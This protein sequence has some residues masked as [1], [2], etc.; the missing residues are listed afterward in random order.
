VSATRDRLRVWA[1]ALAAAGLAAA[2][3]A[4][5]RGGQVCGPVDDET[6]LLPI[7][8]RHAELATYEGDRWLAATARVFSV[9]Y[10]WIVGSLMASIDDPIVALRWL[11]LPFHAV[12]LAGTWRVA[13]RDGGPAAGLVAM[14]LCLVPPLDR[15]VLAPG[16]GLPRDLVFALLPWFL[17]G[18]DATL[19]RPRAGLW[20]F[21]GLGLVANLHP[22]TALHA[23]VWLGAIGLVRDP[24][25]RGLVAALMRGLGFATGAAPYVMQYLARPAAPGAVDQ[26]VYV[27]RL[28]SMGGESV[29]SFALRMETVLL[30][31]A[32]AAVVVL[33]WRKDGGRWPKWFAAAA[34]LALVLAALG[35]TLGRFVVPLRAVQLARF[36]RIAAWCAIVLLASGGVAVWRAGRK[37]SVV[38]AAVLVAAAAWGP[39]L[40]GGVPIRGPLARLGRKL[41]RSSGVPY[42]PPAP[43]GLAVRKDVADPSSPELRDAFLSVCSLARAATPEGALFLVPPEKWGP[44]RVYARRAVAVTRK[45]GGAALSFLG[46]AGMRWFDDYAE[47][48]R[49]YASGDEAAWK[50]LAGRGGASFVIADAG[51][52]APAGWP[53]VFEAAPFRVLAV[54]AK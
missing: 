9:P 26:A 35:P 29:G 40:L 12:F 6:L 18:A 25:P 41:D 36:E 24:S 3:N 1:A 13:E 46:A 53:V 28:G 5:S 22:L 39:W 10:S 30:L 49:V 38:V 23:A 20:L 16:G 51:T 15:I 33:A 11:A 43:P 4:W 45:E 37:R 54:P 44:F 34:A 52:R 31:G 32:A 19:A 21:A 27:W 8:L 14:L 47:A 42:E 17:L 48:V 2:W 50:E 7:A